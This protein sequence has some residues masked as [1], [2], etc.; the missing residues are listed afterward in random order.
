M[1]LVKENFANLK[2]IQDKH[3][4]DKTSYIMYDKYYILL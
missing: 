4:N 2:K 3:K 1:K